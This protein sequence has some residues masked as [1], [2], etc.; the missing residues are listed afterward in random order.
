MGRAKEIIIKVIPAKLANKFIKKYHYSGKVVQNSQLHFGAF[1]DGVLH[2]AMQFGSSLDKRKLMG[3]VKETKWNEFIELNRMAF[4][5]YLPRNSESRCISIAMKLLKKN[6]P[7]IKWVVS[8][9]DA[10]Q[11]GDGTIY[12]ASGFKLTGIKSNKSQ[13]GFNVDYLI[14]HER[15]EI[16][17]LIDVLKKKKSNIL[18]EIYFRSKSWSSNQSILNGFYYN[19]GKKKFI[20]TTK[21]K[22]LQGYQF[23]PPIFSLLLL[24]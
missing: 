5:E 15:R 18:N 4:D 12:R 23:Y 8:F 13:W 10:T 16:K 2:G 9:A 22:I 1:L 17:V 19:L 3:L 21:A 6:A 14:K 7:H 24:R 11:C 20:E